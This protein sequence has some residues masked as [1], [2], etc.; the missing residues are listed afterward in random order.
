MRTALVITVSD[1]AS[2]GQREDLSG[3]K[4]VAILTSA[5]FECP[6]PL[7]VA[8]D[9]DEIVS[10]L[11][12]AVSR[13]TQLVVTTGGTGLSPRDVTPEATAS[14]IS[15]AVPG[16][17]ELMRTEGLK[18]TPMAA[19]SRGIAGVVDQTLVINLPG[20][21]SGVVESLDAVLGILPHALDVLGGSTAH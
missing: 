21:P 19:L 12:G 3:P 18:N 14:V 17:T 8:D 16:L 4:A 15:K 2:S 6:A 9:H 10:A 13:G 1:R 5:G 20:S 7:V 11:E